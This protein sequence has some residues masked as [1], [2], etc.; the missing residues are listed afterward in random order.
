MSGL[1]AG[2]LFTPCSGDARTA[3]RVTSL[4]V[5]AVVGTAMKASGAAVIARPLPTTSRKSSGSLPLVAMAAIAFPASIALPP[6][7]E[8]TTSQPADIPILVRH[9]VE[10]HSRRMGKT[11][12]SIPPEAMAALVAWQWPGNIRELENF[13]AAPSFSRAVRFFTFHWLSWNRW[14][15]KTK[16]TRCLRQSHPP[17]RRARPYSPRLARGQHDRQSHPEPPRAAFSSTSMDT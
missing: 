7:I 10:R 9:F 1:G 14:R 17:G 3:L 16:R 5:P 11:I 15:K 12:E 2:W 13:R 6:P 8:I 4:P